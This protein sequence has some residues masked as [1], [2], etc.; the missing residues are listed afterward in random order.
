MRSLKAGVDR[1][2]PDT[3]S[4]A[5]AGDEE[6]FAVLYHAHAPRMYATCLRLAGGDVDSACDALQDAFVRAWRA[7]P[8]WRGDSAVSTW[9]HRIAVNTSLE[10]LRRDARRHARVQGSDSLDALNAQSPDG[11]VSERLD[12]ERALARLTSAARTLFVLREI[13]GYSY[14]EISE[15]TGTTEMALRAQLVRTRRLLARL[16]DP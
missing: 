15:L 7:L 8:D 9:L 14:A 3:V 1:M 6:A 12:L 4:R 13:E 2:P 11:H 5:T 16:P 10:R